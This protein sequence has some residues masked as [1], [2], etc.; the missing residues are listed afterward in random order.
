MVS[1]LTSKGQITLPKDLRDRLKL[2]TGDQVEF[3]IDE[4]GRIEMVPITASVKRLKGML[5]K[6]KKA[7][8]LEAMDQAIRQRAGRS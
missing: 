6:P 4:D 5:P 2:R 7:V 3:F 1:T 8:T